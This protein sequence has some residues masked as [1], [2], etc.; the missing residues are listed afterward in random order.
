MRLFKA[1]SPNYQDLGEK[2][3]LSLNSSLKALN[4]TGSLAPVCSPANRG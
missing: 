1:F 2:L 4:I 3:L